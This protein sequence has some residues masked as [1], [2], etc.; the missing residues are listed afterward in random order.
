MKDGAQ[1]ASKSWHAKDRVQMPDMS[2]IGLISVS[3][4]SHPIVS[5]LMIC[6]RAHVAQT[7]LKP[8]SSSSPSL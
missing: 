7:L 1:A 8:G 5:I 6:I 3:I 4:F 2:I